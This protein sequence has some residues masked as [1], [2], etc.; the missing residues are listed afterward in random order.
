MKKTVLIILLALLLAGSAFAMEL[1]ELISPEEGLIEYFIFLDKNWDDSYEFDWTKGVDEQG[2]EYV[3]AELLDSWY[4]VIYVFYNL[5]ET[6]VDDMYDTLTMQALKLNR[7]KDENTA[8]SVQDEFIFMNLVNEEKNIFIYDDYIG[9]KYFFMDA[10]NIP[11]SKFS[12]VWVHGNGV[13][14]Y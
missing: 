10:Q 9:H 4:S 3:K 11:Y 5:S 12:V 7:D 14:D 8:G 6:E 2:R 13:Y 1:K